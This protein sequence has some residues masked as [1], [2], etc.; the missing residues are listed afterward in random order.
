MMQLLIAEQLTMGRRRIIAG[1]IFLMYGQTVS[2]AFSGSRLRD[3]SLQ[4]NDAIQWHAIN[5][6]C[7]NDFRYF[8]FGEVP[9]GHDGLARYKSKWGA[10]PMRL[11]RY[12]YPTCPDM[13]SGSE[14]EGYWEKIA[15][16]AWRR[17]PLA[18]ISWLGDRI[19]ARL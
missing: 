15:K 10:K 12:Y 18:A 17:L 16:S 2:Y 6:A 11:Y 9:E 1:S 4:P 14:S 7:R 19:Y 13:E 3:L 5:E 8:D